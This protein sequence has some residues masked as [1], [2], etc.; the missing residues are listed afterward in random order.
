MRIK[1]PFSRKLQLWVPFLRSK[2]FIWVLLPKH[3]NAR[4]STIPMIVIT[5]VLKDLAAQDQYQIDPIHHQF[6]DKCSS[7]WERVVIYDAD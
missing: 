7:F 2:I 1:V 6:I 3:P 4:L 5:V